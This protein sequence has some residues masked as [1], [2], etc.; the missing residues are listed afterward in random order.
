MGGISMRSALAALNLRQL[1]LCRL[2]YRQ[3]GW[4]L[5]DIQGVEESGYFAFS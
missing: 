3:F 1:D 4:L 2:H 5:Q